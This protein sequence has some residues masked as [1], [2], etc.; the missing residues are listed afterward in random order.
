MLTLYDGVR[1]ESQQ[2]GDEHGIIV[3]DYNIERAEIIKGPA[4]LMYGSDAVAGVMSLFPVMPINTNGRV[5]GRYTSEYQ[6]NNGL[7]GNGMRL[8]YGNDHWSYVLRGSFR[9]AKN[10]RD[11][12]DGWVY[13]TNFRTT[14]SSLTIQYKGFAGFTTLNLNL[15]DHKQGIPDGSRDSL[16]RQ[17][18]KQVY[19]IGGNPSD[20]I[21]DR[22]VIPYNSLN[23][24]FLS[25]LHQRVQDYKVYSKS[26][27]AIG[28]GYLDAVIAFTQNLRR[29]YDHPKDPEQAG[30]YVRLYTLNYGMRYTTQTIL[31]TEITFGLNGMYQNNKSKDATDFP[32]PDFNLFDVGPYIYLHR[33]F[34]KWT[35]SGGIRY[36]TRYLRGN[37]FYTR[38]DQASGFVKQV[39]PPDTAGAYLQFPA[40]RKIFSGLSLSMGLTYQINDHISLKANIA[41]GFR[42]P[43]ISE[44]ASNGLDPGAHIVYLGNRNANPEFS[45]QED[46]GI[47]ATYDDVSASLSIF[48]NNIQHYIYETQLT[49]A[50]GN[51]VVVVPGNKTFRYDQAT[52]RLYGLEAALNLHPQFI[53][54][55]SFDIAFTAISGY[56]LKPEYK[57]EGVN[58]EYLP[59]VP[60]MRLLSGICQE[61]KI[62]SKIFT[63]LTL[64][65]QVD[66][67]AA[68]N[69]FLALYQTETSTPGYTLLNGGI[70]TNIKYTKY[71]SFQLQIQVNNVLDQAYQSNQSRLK[72]FEYYT[73]SP[74]G[75]LG[76]YGMG[77]NI[78]IKMLMPF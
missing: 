19:E 73:A 33:K 44:F 32:I 66:F 2:W 17:F 75:H 23:S 48:N 68:Q 55:F 6:S 14:N 50:Q 5:I 61:I 25:P 46:A 71:S 15:Y 49:D 3:D 41:R 34:E 38:Q 63:S 27:Y 53:K 56:N 26:H 18:T 35:V 64:K 4:S 37:N 42:A 72:Y 76:M 47:N 70:L 43:N 12:V 29:E 65:G 11:P 30:L 40:F 77:R 58:G 7:V 9:I 45:L 22:P 1:Q 21:K 10:Y 36:D 78:C 51:P 52:A 20:N 31:N 16:S 54:G 62:K 69:H 13:N 24:Y 59:F 8:I 60:P 74:S 57:N 28:R 39:L 67:N